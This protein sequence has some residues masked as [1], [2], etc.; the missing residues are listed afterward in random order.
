MSQPPLAGRLSASLCRACQPTSTRWASSTGPGPQLSTSTPLTSL[1]GTREAQTAA[2]EC[3]GSALL[4]QGAVPWPPRDGGGPGGI[5]PTLHV[6]GLS[7]AC[8]TPKP[9]SPGFG[10]EGTHGS[11]WQETRGKRGAWAVI[12]SPGAMLGKVS[13][14]APSFPEAPRL[15]TGHLLLSCPE[16]GSCV[17]AA[18]L[19]TCSTLSSR[20]CA[21]I[22]L[23]AV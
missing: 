19:P 14:P 12:P 13:G 23:N 18:R 2:H 3:R 20:T 4:L 1:P 6:G 22:L 10:L 7:P 5:Q 15:T 9:L 11:H 17:A 21:L 16:R 8:G